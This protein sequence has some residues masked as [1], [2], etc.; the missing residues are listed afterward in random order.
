MWQSLGSI[1]PHQIKKAGIARQISDALVCE[2][3]DKIAR[4]I[5]GDAAEHCR[6]VYV[7][8]TVLWVA[9]LSSSLSNEL[10]IYEQDILRA[11]EDKFGKNRIAQLRFM[12]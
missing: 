9:V 3:F 2:E 8:D 5:F 11:L 1:I 7:K 6:A 4:S 12:A 10:K